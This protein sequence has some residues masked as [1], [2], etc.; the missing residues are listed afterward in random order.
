VAPCS[1][2]K[3]AAIPGE[4][5]RLELGDSLARLMGSHSYGIGMLRHD[6]ARFSALLG[7]GNDDGAP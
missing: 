6:L 5:S 4:A 1:D 3:L 7:T 2:N